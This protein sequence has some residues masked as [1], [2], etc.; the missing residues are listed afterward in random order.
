M[1]FFVINCSHKKHQ[2]VKS[3]TECYIDQMIKST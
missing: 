2:N 3:L 1:S